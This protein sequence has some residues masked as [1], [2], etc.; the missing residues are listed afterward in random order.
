MCSRECRTA[1]PGA[2]PEPEVMGDAPDRPADRH[3]PF[4]PPPP[5][6]AAEKDILT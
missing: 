4:R 3:V 5:A 6:P 2:G 1:T